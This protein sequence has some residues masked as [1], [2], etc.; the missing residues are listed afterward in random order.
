MLLTERRNKEI[1]VVFFIVLK[2][3]LSFLINM[4]TFMNG[5][6]FVGLFDGVRW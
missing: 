3:Q 4:V 2:S 6:I 5:R 1:Y